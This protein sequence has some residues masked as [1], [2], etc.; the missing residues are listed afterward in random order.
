MS[1]SICF[2]EGS[3]AGNVTLFLNSQE[4]YTVT[5]TSEICTP[6]EGGLYE[7]C[8]HISGVIWLISRGCA[9]V[10]E[11]TI[12]KVSATVPSN[13]IAP[14]FIEK[15]E[16]VEK[17]NALVYPNPAN[18]FINIAFEGTFNGSISLIDV[19]GRVILKEKSSSVS[20]KLDVSKIPSG[21]YIIQ[22]ETAL[23]AKITEKIT[24]NN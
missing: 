24:I 18:D 3:T 20:T 11:P 2:N 10:C 16:G 8:G 13:N 6:Q 5:A 7:K 21:M 4:F 17:F 22:F 15:V 14:L 19:S 1:K 23:G 9:P 12:P